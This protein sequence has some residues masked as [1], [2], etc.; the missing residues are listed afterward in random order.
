MQSPGAPDCR[1]AEEKQLLGAPGRGIVAEKEWL[2]RSWR[3]ADP[4]RRRDREEEDA[5]GR[6][7]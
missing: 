7:S 5:R 6:G 3:E 4:G 2:R 1:W